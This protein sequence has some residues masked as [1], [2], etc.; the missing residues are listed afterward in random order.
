[1]N[2]KRVCLL[3]AAVCS[4]SFAQSQS[5]YY[6][7]LSR[8]GTEIGDRAQILDGRVGSQGSVVIGSSAKVNHNV[9]AGSHIVLR[10][11]S[12]V[13]NAISGGPII[14]QAGAVV[15][16]NELA[17]HSI[18]VPSIPAIG[19][20]TAGT[21][22]ITVQNGSTV[23]LPPGNYRNVIVRSRS[24]LSLASG[25]YTFREFIIEPD[26]SINF[27]I[28]SVSPVILNIS[29]NMKIESRVVFNMHGN[30]Y[31]WLVRV[32]S[33]QT[34]DFQINTDS[35]ITG[36][37]DVPNAHLSMVSRTILNGALHGKS[38]RID[39]DAVLNGINI[40][41]DGDGLLDQW[42]IAGYDHDNDGV[43]DVDLPAMGAS[44]VHKDVFVEVDW[45]Q[46]ETRNQRPSS[47]AINDVI[48]AFAAADVD[49]PDG[50]TGINLHVE[51]SNAVPFDENLNPVWDEF[52]IIKKDNFDEARQKT[53]HYCI[54]GWTYNSSSSSGMSRGIP[55]SDFV[56]TLAHINSDRAKFS[57]TFMHELGHNLN[58][59]HGG[60]D[61]EHF[62]PNFLSIMNYSFQFSHVP[63]RDGNRLD[64]S[65]FNIKD[66]D[67]NNLNENIG[68]DIVEGTGSDADLD[69]YSTDING[70]I[71]NDCA[72][73]IDYNWNG[74]NDEVGI[75]CDLNRNG[76]TTV[77][78][79]N[80]NDWRNIRYDGL[81][82]GLG[83]TYI[84][85]GTVTESGNPFALICPDVE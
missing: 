82:I 2:L 22:D 66:L 24:S 11:N 42:E 59:R 55:G 9:E 61:H 74:R 72:G 63:H 53:H 19:P 37:F 30:E 50:T 31:P 33:T 54:V 71:I 26:V 44:P 1:M 62:K 65:R 78:I 56:V 36:I 46:D 60:A 18:S 13:V 7:V 16:G 75:S 45:M 49:N 32:N 10:S 85:P 27:N 69:G 83:E 79:G 76:I 57:G 12:R 3:L 64:Y 80:H 51:I 15:S 4:T 38:V 21:E 43:I 68:L 29:H 5:D 8:T 81:T 34:A 58:L 48:Q 14:K 77:L 25:V 28:T 73:P 41:T 52:D 40:D 17:S 39:A 23:V 35:R 6:T 70:F 84:V 20:F 47:D 67:E